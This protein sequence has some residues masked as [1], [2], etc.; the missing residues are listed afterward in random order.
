[1]RK[2][3]TLIM[4]MLVA[5]LS[6]AAE[7]KSFTITL[8]TPA[9]LP[10]D[11]AAYVF[12][13]STYNYSYFN[14][15]ECKISASDTDKLVIRSMTSN[16]VISALTDAATGA[17]MAPDTSFPCGEVSIKASDVE[18]GA[19]LILSFT[20]KQTPKMTIVCE[21]IDVLS[22][23]YQYSECTPQDG[24]FVIS[25]DNEYGSVQIRSNSVDWKL[26]SATG[27]NGSEWNA[28]YLGQISIYC[29]SIYGD[30]TVTVTLRNLLESRT[31]SMTV[32]V[33]GNP[34]D[35]RL[36][37]SNETIP[38]TSA[39]TVVNFDPETENSYSVSHNSYNMNLYQ[40]KVGDRVIERSGSY[41]NFSVADGDVVNIT[42]EFPDTYAPVSFEFAEG[43][44]EDI[45]DTFAV[46]GENV[47][48]WT[49][50]NYQVQLGQRVLITFNKSKYS[51][52]RLKRGSE[53]IYINIYN[54]SYEFTVLDETPI[55]FEVNATIPQPYFV[56]IVTDCPEGLLVYNGYGYNQSEL[57]AL[58]GEESVIEIPSSYNYLTIKAAT[59]Y[60]IENCVDENGNEI[61]IGN[62]NTIEHDMTIFVTVTELK[63]ENTLTLYVEP[64]NQSG[65]WNYCSFTL[66]NSDYDTRVMYSNQSEPLL[67]YG[68]NFIK[69]G[70]FDLPF[71][72][73]GYPSLYAYLN[74]EPITIEYGSMD[75]EQEI[76]DG[77]VIKLFR[78][79]PE[80][81]C[82]TYEIAEDVNVTVHH[83]HTRQIGEPSVHTVFHGTEIVIEGVAEESPVARVSAESKSAI[84]V[85]VGDQEVMPDESGKFIIAV[86]DDA[87]I[88]VSKNETV[89]I[90]AIE[91]SESEDA[92]VYNLQGIRVGN[93][94][95]LNKMPK[96]T[97]ISAGRK[98]RN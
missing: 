61:R 44:G 85:K 72:I 79:E 13:P 53:D 28:D 31:A 16:Y 36:S 1:M 27:S 76:A 50:E 96:G 22:V 14:G 60:I 21:R 66:S 39:S 3:Y 82:V 12:N 33:D 18:E 54:P 78:T 34:S 89:G 56:T 51:D 30:I 10:T 19:N 80:S 90:D 20:E 70:N 71:A 59:G 45:I 2:L 8:D 68:Y 91:V 5:V 65:S 35:V 15:T 84:A 87:N 97:Y 92:P 6:F 4:V 67:S 95:E 55:V 29:G 74:D 32:N 9:G 11:Q 83:D 81:H 37:R 17:N 25:L 77:D 57:I 7:A 26:V 88:S 94:S 38:L 69:Y 41:F 23:S 62:S 42:T 98:I 49:P 46:N 64:A 73:S 40:V 58:T 75:S 52:I 86:S 93:V 47:S 48:D 63:R 43:I 24:K